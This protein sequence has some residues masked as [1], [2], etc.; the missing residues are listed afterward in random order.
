VC[1]KKAVNYFQVYRDTVF[2]NTPVDN[3]LYKYYSGRIDS[4]DKKIDLSIVYVDS[5]MII[6]TYNT[7]DEIFIHSG[8]GYE[9]ISS[10]PLSHTYN[11]S[12]EVGK[13]LYFFT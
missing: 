10:I 6:N 7:S 9:K 12:E 3:K 8:P 5:K 4:S 1:S 2:F 11:Y 13:Y